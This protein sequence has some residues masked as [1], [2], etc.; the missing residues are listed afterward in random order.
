MKSQTC[1]NLV[2]IVALDGYVLNPGDN[3]WDKVAALGELTVYDRTPQELL[4]ERAKDA[5]IL[6]TNKTILDKSIIASLPRL[7]YISVLATGY[8]TVD[9]EA[10]GG[11]GIPVSNVPEYSTL[12]VAQHTFALILELTNQV[13]L[14]DT[15]VKEGEWSASLDY[16]FWKKPQIELAGLTLGIVGFGRIG[17]AVARIATAFGMR[18]I[19]HTPRIPTNPPVPFVSLDELFSTADVIS[20]HCPQT[21][22]SKGFVSSSLLARMKRSALLINTS[23]GAL[24]NEHDLAAALDTGILAGA[25]VDVASQEPILPDNPLLSAQN[26]L[27]TPHIAWASLAARQR[28]MAETANNVAAFLSGTPVNVVNASF[29]SAPGA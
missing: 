12:T 27:I 25:A 10:A 9:V 7:R 2:K 11:R 14:H 28:L 13:G 21:P 17:R 26:C 18:V 3:P 5:D 23:R 29:V 8:N 15:A 24:I 22:E 1:G 4:L 19:T 20:L 6:L 16:S